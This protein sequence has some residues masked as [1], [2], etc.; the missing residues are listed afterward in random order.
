MRI[1]SIILMLWHTLVF[2]QETLDVRFLQ[3][4]RTVGN[5]FSIPM[6]VSASGEVS[7]FGTNGSQDLAFTPS[8]QLGLTSAKIEYSLPIIINRF[9]FYPIQ[10]DLGWIEVRRRRLEFGAGLTSIIKSS[11]VMGLIPYKGSMQTI[12]RYKNSQDEKSLPFKMP[13]DLEELRQWNEGDSGVFQTYGGISAYA[14][15]SSGIVDL[16]SVS[17]G[18]Q[19]QFIVEIKKIDADVITLKISEESLKKRQLNL[20]PRVSQASFAKFNGSKFTA[21]FNLDLREPLHHELFKAALKGN[22]KLLQERISLKNQKLFWEGRERQLYLGIPS[23]AGIVKDQ[24]HYELNEDGVETELDITGKRN[25]GY[26]TP[27]RNFQNYVYQTEESIVLVWSA[28]MNKVNSRV[29]DKAFLSKGRILGVKG[30]NRKIPEDAKFG[31]MVS[32]IGIHISRHEAEGAKVAD[33]KK[34]TDHLIQKCSDEKL[35]C[36]KNKK[37]NKIIG[38]FN[39]LI[40]KPWEDMKADMGDLLI[41]E[42]ALVYAVV[43]ALKYEKEVY[44]KFLSEKY[45]SL[46]GSAA[47]EL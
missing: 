16:V 12:V 36:R 4:Q 1:F 41:K 21:T 23:I 8:L 46:E 14:G 10:K 13:S 22:L 40:K 42:P 11:A 38:R 47:I 33:I 7:F 30:F 26:L 5:S 17:F 20:G 9:N 32:Q 45:Q 25:R 37:L 15:F 19:N 39:E 18:I 24:G 6:S 2:A 27:L 34:I 3:T 28:E 43:K 31:S 29:F 35:E 44:F